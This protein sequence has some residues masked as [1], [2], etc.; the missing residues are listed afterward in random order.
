MLG[1]VD[2][3][4]WLVGRNRAPV[5]AFLTCRC[6]LRTVKCQ[7]DF[8]HI[9]SV[10][11]TKQGCCVIVTAANVQVLIAPGWDYFI[12]DEEFAMDPDVTELSPDLPA[13]AYSEADLRQLLSACP[14]LQDITLTIYENVRLS[15]LTALPALRELCVHGVNNVSMVSLPALTQLTNLR[16]KV[17]DGVHVTSLLRLTTLRDLRRL[18]VDVEAVETPVQWRPVMPDY[19]CGV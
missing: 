4:Q 14:A 11:P 9:S 5:D 18:C 10:Q 17:T 7:P 19:S 8:V 15:P 12:P 13:S 2:G 16:A 6:D 3:M 1:A